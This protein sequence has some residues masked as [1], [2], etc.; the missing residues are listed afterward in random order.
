[1]S[2]EPPAALNP[3]A[4]PDAAHSREVL[5]IFFPMWNEEDYIERA[6]ASAKDVCERMVAA[7]IIGDYELIVVDD[8]STDRTP[9]I[10]DGIAAADDHVRGRAPPGQP[11]AR[12]C[13]QDRLRHRPWRPRAV[14]R[15]RPALRLRAR[16][17]GPSACCVT[18]TPTCVSAYRLDRTGEGYTTGDLHVLLQPAHPHAVRGQGRATS[19][20]R[21]SC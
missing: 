4:A 17:R 2:I 3:L 5:S 20:S 8:C 12:R 13:D 11:Q 19:T 7:G 18:T 1:M 21:S 9:E 14:L 6:V 16:C 15:R 10:A